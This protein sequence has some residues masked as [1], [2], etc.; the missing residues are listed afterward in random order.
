MQF[1]TVKLKN[2]SESNTKPEY[3]KLK[4]DIFSYRYSVSKNF[5]YKGRKGISSKSIS[6]NESPCQHVICEQEKHDN[7]NMFHRQQHFYIS[8]QCLA[9]CWRTEP[10]DAFCVL[11]TMNT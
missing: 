1:R 9:I 11:L 5:G 7:N 3:F 4:T 2:V 10:T 6:F 8:N